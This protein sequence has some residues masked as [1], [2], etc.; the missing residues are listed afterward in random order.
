MSETQKITGI[1]GVF[2]KADDADALRR[3]YGE[4]LG[5]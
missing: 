5:I 4:N 1:G 3:W 2:F